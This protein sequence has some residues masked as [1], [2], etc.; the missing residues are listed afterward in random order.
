MY[1]YIYDDF[2]TQGKYGKLLYQ[3]EKRLTDLNLNGKTI[4]L[5]VSKNI[6]AAVNDEI[7]IGTKTIVAVGNDKTVSEIIN[8]IINNQS[9]E[10][11][12]VTL[13]IIPID[14]K[15]SKTAEALGIKSI[16]SACEILLARRLETFQLAEINQSYFLFKAALNASNSI[17][18]IDKS[19]IIQNLKPAL[20]EII[21]RPVASGEQLGDKKLEM[22][23]YNKE[24]KSI[25]LFKD[26]LI[27][28]KESAIIT[29]D[30]LVIQSPARIKPGK[31]RIKIIVGKE[32][33]L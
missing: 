14:Q 13:G 16:G 26:L 4:R 3:I 19:F 9:D 2:I 22:H 11:R 17:M 25:V 5:G 1:A 33:K 18:E 15:E 28:N 7:R 8:H 23:I 21:N 31:E 29:D 12:Q 10:S 32:R 20:V 24:G 30:S 27:T 6:K